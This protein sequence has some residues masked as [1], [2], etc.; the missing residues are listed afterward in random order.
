MLTTNSA[1][2]QQNKSIVENDEKLPSIIHLAYHRCVNH[3]KV[4]I[5]SIA[6]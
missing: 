4:T 1:L 6:R 5:N 3:E 2:L